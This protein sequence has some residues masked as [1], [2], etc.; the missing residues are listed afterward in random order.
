MGRNHKTKRFILGEVKK[1]VAKVPGTNDQVYEVVYVEIIDPLERGKTHLPATFKY[2]RTN[3]KITVDQTNEFYDGPSDYLNP[4]WK[5]PIPMNVSVDRNDVF[6]G[7]PQ[8]GIRFPSSIS[9]WRYRLKNMAD[10]LKERNYM[11]LWMRSIQPGDNQEL[12]YVAAVP[13][14]YCKPGGA[15]DIILNIKNS[16]FDFKLLDYTVDRYIIDSVTGDYTDKYLV[17][18]NDRTSIT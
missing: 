12:D 17:F 10:T 5:R 4:F 16:G 1:A 18:R 15:D 9:L 13:L 7:D 14:C 6:A 2:S 3:T 8:T 11:P